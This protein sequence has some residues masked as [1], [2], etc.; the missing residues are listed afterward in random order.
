MKIRPQIIS[1]TLLVVSLISCTKSPP[2][3]QQQSLELAT[4]SQSIQQM[5]IE[6]N[7][8]DPR[9][10]QER[11]Q[12]LHDFFTETYDGI[13][14]FSIPQEMLIG[15]RLTRS[16]WNYDQVFGRDIGL[17]LW[18]QNRDVPVYGVS[19][20]RNPTSGQIAFTNNCL[21]CHMAE[22]DGTVYFGVGTK[23][24]DEKRLVEVAI[25]ST[26]PVARR[27]LRLPPETDQQMQHV[28]QTLKRQ[29]HQKTDPLTRGSFTSLVRSHVELYRS[30]NQGESPP[31]KAVRRGDGKTPP[32][33]H[34]VAKQPFGRWYLDGSLHGEHPLMASSMELPKGRTFTDLRQIAIP[35]IIKQFESVIAQIR[36]PTYPDHINS[37]LAQKGKQLFYSK[38][39]GCSKCHGVYDGRGNVDWTG[40]HIDVGTDP[41]RRNIVSN[42]FIQAFSQSPLA[43]QLSLVKSRGYAA[44]PLTGVWANFPYLHNGSV[45][46]LYHL[47]G[48]VEDRPQI[49]FTYGALYLDKQK[50]GQHL[51]PKHFKRTQQTDDLI[52]KYGQDRDWYNVNRTGADN[53]GHDFWPLIKTNQNRLALIEYLKTL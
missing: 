45:P 18:P 13:E 35:T 51:Y 21:M 38:Q 23:I 4:F 1:L 24:F 14:T 19:A 28:H 52:G 29:Q 10:G 3:L 36:P 30:A 6:W 2:R 34:Y 42:A 32:L 44:T 12:A 25:E 47:L 43:D 31:V 7:P 26:S 48:P 33:W 17:V 49:F 20:A 50:V 11:M 41:A 16:I 53:S 15:N 39:I 8:N 9:S 5:E 37:E 27:M 22:I 40:A 46:T